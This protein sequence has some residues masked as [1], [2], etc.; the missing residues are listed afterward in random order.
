MQYFEIRYY[1]GLMKLHD[2]VRS[3][4][5]TA[6][7]KVYRKTLSGL[8]LDGNWRYHHVTLVKKVTLPI[9]LILLYNNPAIQCMFLF[10]SQLGM[11]SVHKVLKPYVRDWATSLRVFCECLFGMVVLVYSVIGVYGTR[12]NRLIVKDMDYV[13]QYEMYVHL[14]WFTIGV[15]VLQAFVYVILNLSLMVVIVY[16]KRQGVSG[17]VREQDNN[18]Q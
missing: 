3:S 8:N 9:I 18:Q 4:V 2:C 17:G 13:G 14:G 10:L 1:L 11:I 12:I 5:V 16:E 6:L 15:L 7:G